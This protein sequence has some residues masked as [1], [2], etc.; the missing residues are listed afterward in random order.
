MIWQIFK[1][2]YFFIIY[3][4]KY[5]DTIFSLAFSA[6]FYISLYESYILMIL[7]NPNWNRSIDFE[8]Y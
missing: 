1:T 6:F 4:L 3:L 2:I 8:L 5:V 7:S